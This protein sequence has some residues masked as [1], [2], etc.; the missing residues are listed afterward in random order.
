MNKAFANC[1]KEAEVS[2][3]GSGDMEH[4]KHVGKVSTIMRVLASKDGAILS[5]FD[6]ADESRAQ[7]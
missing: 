5:Q 1:F 6:K 7:I 4:N 3:N 2:T